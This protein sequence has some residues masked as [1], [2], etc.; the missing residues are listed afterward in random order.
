MLELR[1]LNDEIEKFEIFTVEDNEV[2]T[3]NEYAEPQQDNFIKACYIVVGDNGCIGSG[4]REFK[5]FIADS[6]ILTIDNVSYVPVWLA[7]R[8]QSD[9]FNWDNIISK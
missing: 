7:K 8:I 9:S 5:E 6:L 2:I 4:R 3:C 1:I